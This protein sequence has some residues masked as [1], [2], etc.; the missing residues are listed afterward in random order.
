MVDL[1]KENYIGDDMREYGCENLSSVREFQ[2]LRVDLRETFCGA[3]MISKAVP[4]E[5]R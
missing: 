2:Q 1:L 4:L 3:K 5:D